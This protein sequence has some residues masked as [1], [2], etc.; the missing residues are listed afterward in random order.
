[1]EGMKSNL[2]Q[3]VNSQSM[4]KARRAV[5]HAY[6]RIRRRKGGKK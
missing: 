4:E 2:A 5:C 3:T 1:M 6:E